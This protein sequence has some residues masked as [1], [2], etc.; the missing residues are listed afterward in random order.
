MINT[1]LPFDEATMNHITDS[2]PAG[3]ALLSEYASPS[4]QVSIARNIP[5]TDYNIS[6][7]RSLNR[8]LKRNTNGITAI[9]IRWR[10]PRRPGPA[11]QSSCLRKDATHFAVYWC[12]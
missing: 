10:G 4:T 3:L 7:I 1:S 9:N 5:A 2:N 12:Y 6:L 8:S 11:G